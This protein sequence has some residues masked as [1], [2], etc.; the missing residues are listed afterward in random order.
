M[1]KGFLARKGRGPEKSKATQSSSGPISAPAP[2]GK[3]AS[4]PPNRGLRTGFLT[5]KSVP[6]KPARSPTPDPTPSTAASKRSEQKSS[7]DTPRLS[8]DPDRQPK[9]NSQEDSSST[10]HAREPDTRFKLALGP[11]DSAHVQDEAGP[12]AE[13]DH[14]RRTYASLPSVLPSDT[15]TPPPHSGLQKGFFGRSVPKGR[16]QADQA[17]PSISTHSSSLDSN[18]HRPGDAEVPSP[19]HDGLPP[20]ALDG[21][22]GGPLRRKRH[23]PPTDV[24]VRLH[25]VCN[26]VSVESKHPKGPNLARALTALRALL[27]EITTV[28]EADRSASSSLTSLALIAPKAKRMDPVILEYVFHHL[29]LI[30]RNAIPRA[31]TDTPPSTTNDEKR[32]PSS[33]T[34]SDAALE[35]TFSCLSLLALD[36]WPAFRLP[37]VQHGSAQKSAF[38]LLFELGIMFL[39]RAVHTSEEK[40]MASTESLTAMCEFL[41]CILRPRAR[42]PGEEAEEEQIPSLTSLEDETTATET[43]RQ[44]FAAVLPKQ[45]YPSTELCAAASRPELDFYLQIRRLISLCCTFI[46]PRGTRMDSNLQI[47]ALRLMRIA[48]CTWIIGDT[49]QPAEDDL[50]RSILGPSG[51]G[52]DPTPQA[53]AAS[54]S[55]N[56]VRIFGSTGLISPS[57]A[58]TFKARLDGHQNGER[59]L[60]G[61]LPET[62]S[63]LT[64]L[65]VLSDKSSGGTKV[66]SPVST[67]AFDTLRSLL[68]YALNDA[69]LVQRS[70]HDDETMTRVGQVLI[71]LS[72]QTHSSA[73][74]QLAMVRFACALLSEC[75]Q[76]LVHSG[77]TENQMGHVQSRS[78]HILT[79]WLIDLA[80]PSHALS[81]METARAATLR[82]LSLPPSPDSATSPA[83]MMSVYLATEL[84]SALEGLGGHIQSKKEDLVSRSCGWTESI[85]F[86]ALTGEGIR[87]E[88]ASALGGLPNALTILLTARDNVWLRDLITALSQTHA[89]PSLSSPTA[90]PEVVLPGMSASDG[91]ALDS[92][93]VCI[94]R[95]IAKLALVKPLRRAGLSPLPLITSLLSSGEGVGLKLDGTAILPQTQA[96]LLIAERVLAGVNEVF[97][98]SALMNLPSQKRKVAARLA[99]ELA[100]ECTQLVNSLFERDSVSGVNSS[101]ASADVHSVSTSKTP[102]LSPGVALAKPPTSQGELMHERGLSPA[103]H[104]Q[105][106]DLFAAESIFDVS[107]VK[108]ATLSSVSKSG[109]DASNTVARQEETQAGVGVLVPLLFTHASAL[110]GPGFAGSFIDVIYNVVR[111]LASPFAAARDAATGALSTI[112][113]NTGYPD[114][115]M[116]VLDNADYIIS[117]AVMALRRGVSPTLADTQIQMAAQAGPLVLVELV[118]L[119]GSEAVLHIHDAVEDLLDSLDNFHGYSNYVSGVTQVL[120]GVV[121]VVANQPLPEGQPLPVEPGQRQPRARKSCDEHIR[122]ISALL[123][124]HIHPGS[125]D[126]DADEE[127]SE[128][129]APHEEEDKGYVDPKKEDPEGERLKEIV[130]SIM[131]RA[132]PLLAHPASLLRVQAIRLLAGGAASLSRLSKWESALTMMARAWPHLLIRLNEE[133]G[134]VPLEALSTLGTWATIAPD[135]LASRLAEEAWPKIGRLVERLL[136]ACGSEIS[137]EISTFHPNARGRRRDLIL[138]IMIA[139]SQ[140]SKALGPRMNQDVAWSLCCHPV[141]LN[142]LTA[143][144]DPGLYNAALNLFRALTQVN[145]GAV[146]ASLTAATATE[147]SVWGR[148][149][150]TPHTVRLGK[151]VPVQEVLTQDMN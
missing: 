126:E 43:I 21:P 80:S 13:I 17:H 131:D 35:Q 64:Q 56:S 18:H 140:I 99:G 24:M 26:Q 133:A 102:D 36:W 94:G 68:V 62:V 145:A 135:F 92:M 111:G 66:T 11:V 109:V 6:S 86:T 1:Q 48:A 88:A 61:I 15:P 78:V 70:P 58:R 71:V 79:R 42:P 108:P 96:S 53:H 76:A 89:H 127:A 93:L 87:V 46:T 19:I 67:L 125:Q 136:P 138:G 39:E 132:I 37:E 148:E 91:R 8:T 115:R 49:L 117:R 83:S 54:C 123:Q 141:F 105:E 9:P 3:E 4:R 23:L 149:D 20:P 63:R 144:Q 77:Q 107:F 33:L 41:F 32:K 22:F 120:T 95:T 81:V 121:E 44:C 25:Q 82:I 128:E 47:A 103:G 34:I 124:A 28:P 101:D 84:R 52:L 38:V 118:R 30:L 45:L 114:L 12:A 129:V 7:E 112:A 130:E 139:L 147:L 143:R 29:S 113:Y 110:T 31:P 151:S 14:L 72:E 16:S 104:S 85:L 98:H 97:H 122:S 74:T 10:P 142:A 75:S 50:M 69:A 119:L 5:G 60:G 90:S 59:L 73:G 65:L 27:E 55:L 106:V 2:C 40:K 51:A 116:L 150:C 134:Q 146:W 57:T 137:T 100:E